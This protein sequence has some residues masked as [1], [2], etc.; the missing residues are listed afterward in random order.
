MNN[1][2]I[3][4]FLIVFLSIY[5]LINYYIGLRAWQFLS[6]FFTGLNPR[7]Y[8]GVLAFVVFSYLVARLGRGYL[9]YGVSWFLTMLGSYWI[10][11]MFYLLQIILLLDII[12]LLVKYF[13]K[14]LSQY[15]IPLPSFASIGILVTI[16]VTGILIYG[17][18]NAR[19]PIIQRYD[20]TIPKRAGTMEELHIVMASDIHLGEII[21]RQRLTGM[22]EIIQSLE[23]D[24]I[25]LPGD[26]IDEDTGPFVNQDMASVFKK[27]NP[28]YGIYAVPGNHEYIGRGVDK[29]IYYL[30][31]AGIR[32]LRDSSIKVADSFYLV[33]RDD[34]ARSHFSKEGEAAKERKSLTLLMEE[35]DRSFPV[36]L[37]SHQP[38][39]LEEASQQGVDLQ[40]SG[41]THRGQMFPNHLLTSRIFEIDWG[42]LR[43][44]GLQVIVSSGIGTWG[45]PI[46]IGNRPEVVDIY[47]SFV[48]STAL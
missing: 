18:W 39:Y 45:P 27:L 47:V 22:V 35:I 34:D 31:Q 11:A 19:H 44:G 41:H 26:I 28:T 23:P 12:R 16:L 10:A 20:I 38:R 6:L 17:T 43:K 37:L 30:E 40:L 25:L 8:W 2:V 3:I 1:T 29:A 4:L 21:H 46:R 15:S 7:F 5:G 14:H 24:I 42:Y 33:G 36:I 9:P 13:N 32:V 48:E